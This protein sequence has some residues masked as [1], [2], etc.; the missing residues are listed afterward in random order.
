MRA[1][2]TGGLG[3][4]GIHLVYRLLH[5]GYEVLVYDVQRYPGRVSLLLAQSRLSVLKGD[6]R[7]VDQLTFVVKDFMPSHVFHLAALHYIPDC[8]KEPSTT[9]SVNCLGTMG[10]A[11][12]LLN[13]RV[14]CSFILAST[15]GVYSSTPGPEGFKESDQSEPGDIY[16]LSKKS[17]ELIIKRYH[18]IS[19]NRCTVTRFFNVYGEYETNLHLIPEILTQLQRQDSVV[20]GNLTSKRDFIHVDD[21]VDAL[22]RLAQI[23]TGGFETFNIGGGNP[24]NALE[25]VNTMEKILGRSINVKQDLSRV[26][27]F[28]P[29]I[30]FADCSRLKQRTGWRPRI[31]IGQG[32]ERLMKSGR[33]IQR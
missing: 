14:Q 17:S 24:M 2:V 26:R 22:L 16:G 23:E 30:L 27:L 15:A 21:L 18:R 6:I 20:L 5:E 19:G 8:E 31:A 11:E 32:L 9:L 3:F 29:P 25:I 28:D 13:K 10:L 4:I 12:A 1:L 7:D 33:I